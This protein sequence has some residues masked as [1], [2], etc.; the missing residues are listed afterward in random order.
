M[1]LG[2]LNEMLDDIGFRVTFAD[3]DIVPKIEENGNPF[4]GEP[5]MLKWRSILDRGVEFHVTLPQACFIDNVVLTVG[6]TA[7]VTC[8]Q[9]RKDG[10]PIYRYCGETGYISTYY[11]DST[12]SRTPDGEPV[13]IYRLEYIP[14]KA[15]PVESVRLT[16]DP[17][18]DTKIFLERLE[19]VPL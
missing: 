14:K 8:V 13:T 18:Y 2:R 19:A 4:R 11:T 5:F 3:I 10:Q 12:L 9:L 15:L 6:E 1:R 7:A 17:A 16:Q